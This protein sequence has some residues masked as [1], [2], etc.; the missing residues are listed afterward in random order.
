MAQT[1][2]PDNAQ[3]PEQSGATTPKEPRIL[4]H[5]Y[6]QQAPGANTRCPVCGQPYAQGGV[7]VPDQQQTPAALQPEQAEQ[8]PAPGQQEVIRCAACGTYSVGVLRPSPN[9]PQ[10]DH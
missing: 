2:P 5:P 6:A 10:A 3:Q 8:A 4:V 7:P 1:L 9:S